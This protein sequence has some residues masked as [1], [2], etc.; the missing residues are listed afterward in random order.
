MAASGACYAELGWI[1]V[2][3]ELPESPGGMMHIL[4]AL[5]MPTKT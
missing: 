5:E 1:V 3:E 2:D 4:V